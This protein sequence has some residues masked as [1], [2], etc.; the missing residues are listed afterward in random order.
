M[1]EEERYEQVSGDSVCRASVR[2]LGAVRSGD[3]GTAE[4]AVRAGHGG[5]VSECGQ[6]ASVRLSELRLPGGRDR[7]GDG[8]LLPE[9]AD[10]NRAARH[11]RADL[12]VQYDLRGARG[13]CARGDQA[14]RQGREDRRQGQRP[15]RGR[16]LPDGGEHLRSGQQAAGGDGPGAGNRRHH[17]CRFEGDGQETADSGRLE[18]HLRSAGRCAVPALRSEDRRSRVAS[19]AGDPAQGRGEGKR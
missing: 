18:Q 4:G 10:R 1:K 6:C 13:S 7:G 12:P 5:E 17:P 15:R 8:R 9:G 16:A 11:A 2:G 14:G 3:A 19:A